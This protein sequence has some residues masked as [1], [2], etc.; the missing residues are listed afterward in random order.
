M[1]PQTCAFAGDVK[2][3]GSDVNTI[4]FRAHGADAISGSVPVWDRGGGSVD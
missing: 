4:A 2:N 1:R 3:D